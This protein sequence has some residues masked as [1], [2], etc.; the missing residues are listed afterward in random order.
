[1]RAPLVVLV[2]AV[3][4][5]P[6]DELLRRLE[7]V[8]ALPAALRTRLWVQLRDPA[9]PARERLRLAR[10][11]RAATARLGASLIVNDR[12]DLA[13]AVGAD[14]AHLGSRSVAIADARA[15]L[16]AG[17]IVSIACHSVDDVAA[18]ASAGADAVTLSPVFAS[19]GKGAPVGV[20]ALRAARARIDARTRPAL[21]ALGGVDAD[22]ASA[23]LDA[24]A[25]GV[26]AIRA[27]PAAL[28]AACAAPR[29]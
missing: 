26:A 27:D 14:G 5:V 21:I 2:T 23:C 13:I 12:L 20:G 22:L 3:D 7:R 15:L 29:P 8:A 9:L 24:G 4:V 25:D 1:V 18:T 6:E 28:L 19:P 16:G 11:L 17:A 10:S